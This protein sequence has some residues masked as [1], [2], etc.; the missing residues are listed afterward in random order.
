MG[1]LW[2]VW[3]RA[4][5]LVGP[6]DGR[7]V[8]IR[9]VPRT[10][11][12]GRG[13]RRSPSTSQCLGTP[14][15]T[16]CRS[17]LPDIRQGSARRANSRPG[18]L[19]WA[20]HSSADWWV[21]SRTRRGL[22]VGRRR[23]PSC[24]DRTNGPLKYGRI[25]AGRDPRI[26]WRISGTVGRWQLTAPPVLVSRSVGG[27]RAAR[28]RE[29]GRRAAAGMSSSCDSAPVPHIGA[30]NSNGP[31]RCGG[32]PRVLDTPLRRHLFSACRPRSEE[33]LGSATLGRPNRSSFGRSETAPC[34]RSARVA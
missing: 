15:P 20:R 23:H 26:L 12:T 1:N 31:D 29:R 18:L 8:D 28:S 6:S 10:A 30:R 11:R 25:G 9:I 24:V 21:V 33:V 27:R 7:C 34:F 13:S 4:R 22:D 3:R 17:T 32:A 2:I 5:E 19:F 14:A 16:P